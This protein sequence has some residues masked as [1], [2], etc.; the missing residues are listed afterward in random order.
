MR[1]GTSGW[2]GLDGLYRPAE[3]TF[4]LRRVVLVST[5]SLAD[6]SSS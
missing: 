2:K 5:E 3:V 4:T 1:S 6:S